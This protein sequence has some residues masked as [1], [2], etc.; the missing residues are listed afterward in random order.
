MALRYYRSVDGE[1]FEYIAWISGNGNQ[2]TIHKY[3]YEDY[4]IEKGITY[5]Y[6]LKANRLRWSV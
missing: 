6:Q 1:N 5:Y 3:S 2:T 4:S